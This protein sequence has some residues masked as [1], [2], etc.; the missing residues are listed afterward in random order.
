MQLVEVNNLEGVL[1]YCSEHLSWDIDEEYFEDI[2]DLVF[3]FSPDELGIKDECASKIRFIK[4]L[5]PLVDS[6]S[7]GVFVVDFDNSKLEV[8]ALRRILYAFAKRKNNTERKTWEYSQLLFICLWGEYAYRTIGFVAFE[9][10]GALPKLKTVYVS[11]K[12]ED[13]THLENF[14]DRIRLLKWPKDA[15]D[16]NW[17]GEWC[18]SFAPAR[19][20]TISDTRKMTEIL[21]V[22]AIK[23][24]SSIMHSFLIEN[25]D[26]PTH[27]LLSRFKGALN[28]DMSEK[29][30]ADMYAQTIVYGLFSARCL[31]PDV[32]PFSAEVAIEC[33]PK[34]N[35]LIRSLLKE[36]CSSEGGLPFDEYDTAELLDALN[37]TNI[38]NILVDFNR[39]TGSGKEDPIIYFYES[40]LDLYEKEQKKR[41]GVYYTPA[42]AVDFMVK[43]VSYILKN[44]LD[45][46]N[47]FYDDS[48]SV[49][50][51]AVGTG[52]FLR[53]VILDIYDEY[54]KNH[55]SI[56]EW[57]DYVSTNVLERLFGFELMMAPYAVAHMKLAMTLNETGYSMLAD[58]RINVFLTNSLETFETDAGENIDP[59]SVE[60]IFATKTK[61]NGVSVVLGN[62]PYRTDSINQGHWIMNLM[63]DYKKEPG[64]N[65]RLNE[66]NPK[67]V[68][69]DYVKFMRLAQEVIKNQDKAVVSFVVPH[70]FTDNLTFRGM[71]WS[72][73]TSYD[74]IYILDLH[75]NAMSREATANGV[76]DENIFDIQQ[77][78]CICFLIKNG[79]GEKN[80]AVHYADL[81]GTR[82]E[83][84]EY[85]FNSVISDVEWVAMNP[86]A[87]NYF[88]KP[89]N[90]VNQEEYERGIK[91]SELFPQSMVGIKTS[92]DAELIAFSKFDT[93]YDELCDYRPF[94]IRHVNYDRSLVER[95]RYD[96]VRHFIGHNNLGLVIDRQAVT[97]NWS[98]VQIVRN[99]IDNRTHYSRKGNPVLCPMFL[100]AD[101]GEPNINRDMVKIIEDAIEKKFSDTLV[102]DD[103]YFDMKDLFSYCYAV[104]SSNSYRQQYKD[105]L[106]IDFPRV[107]V[108]TSFDVFRELIHLG[109]RLMTLHLMECEI[110]N[111]LN[112]EFIGDGDCFVSG[113]S[114]RDNKVYINRTQCFTNVREDLWDFCFGGYH[115]LQKWLKDRRNLK[116]SIT[117]IEHVIKVFNI[118]DITESIMAD[119][120][121]VLDL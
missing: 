113:I 24:S 77:G 46:E 41:R 26:G 15:Q 67:V 73:Y 55:A 48:V 56:N 98:H 13:R 10:N 71:R 50:D 22:E 66:R 75:G 91:I 21:A 38:K 39:R 68:N 45:I 74:E 109:N 9:E 97:D 29:E 49:L 76:T 88:F 53:R 81:F 54:R 82:E 72:L 101:N 107:P 86:V 105:L 42:A 115:G 63:M 65:E 118:F 64:T 58:N 92:N 83:K 114:F 3:D 62:P 34:T 33:I 59:L 106:C 94:D 32:L 19:G 31:N 43:S 18:A 17:I 95:D 12:I 4:Q 102:D 99:M 120:D 85:L 6:Q 89:K 44:K 84:Y 28:L 90:V 8:A 78:I 27:M 16:T 87:P 7:W 110:E 93:E 112:I 25:N 35:P 108:P 37:R 23:I 52:T 111:N 1:K 40:F 60:S 117:D 57:N 2:D 11:P 20:Q 80:A 36:C 30:F 51:P 104:L 47:G 70:S 96:I 121:L 69:D 100:L 5:R 103:D 61:L 116:L 79:P 14:E 119:I